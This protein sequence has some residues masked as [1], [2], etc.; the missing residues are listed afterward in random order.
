MKTIVWLINTVF[1]FNTDQAPREKDGN[2]QNEMSQKN[3]KQDE[4]RDNMK[5]YE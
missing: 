1:L 3:N 2:M 4:E 5:S